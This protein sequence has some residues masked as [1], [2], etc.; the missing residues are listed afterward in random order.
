MISSLS[1]NIRYN[2]RTNLQTNRQSWNIDD[3]NSFRYR[4]SE[5]LSSQML[6]FKCY[7]L[8]NPLR[9]Q[10]YI[11]D[12][13]GFGLEEWRLNFILKII[14]FCPKQPVVWNVVWKCQQQCCLRGSSLCRSYW[15]IHFNTNINH[16]Y[17]LWI[18]YCSLSRWHEGNISPNTFIQ[19]QLIPEANVPLL[20]KDKWFYRVNFTIAY[21]MP[22]CIMNGYG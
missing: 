3:I 20:S 19:V 11:P 14:S 22:N 16:R 21:N 10:A 12:I 8:L 7:T 6:H 4:Q 15:I 13:D 5:V 17:Q 18:G 2:N 9:T 1:I